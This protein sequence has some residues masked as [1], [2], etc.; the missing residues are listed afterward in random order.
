M[1]SV[2]ADLLFTFNNNHQVHQWK[3]V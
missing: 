1:Y 2:Y 3:S